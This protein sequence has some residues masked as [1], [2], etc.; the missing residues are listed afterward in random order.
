MK[1]DRSSITSSDPFFVP[2]RRRRRN[3]SRDSAHRP[4]NQI[5]SRFIANDRTLDP[6]SRTRAVWKFALPLVAF[7]VA[8]KAKRSEPGKFYRAK[9][10]PHIFAGE[11]VWL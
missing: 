9:R 8:N 10:A 1:K 6:V 3:D 5:E 4:N 7:L 11:A 2:T